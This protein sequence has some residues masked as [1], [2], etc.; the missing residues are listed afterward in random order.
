MKNQLFKKIHYIFIAKCFLKIFILHIKKNLKYH[1][2][3]NETKGKKGA[4]DL[5]GLSNKIQISL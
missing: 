1:N 3:P 4:H 5:N 2:L